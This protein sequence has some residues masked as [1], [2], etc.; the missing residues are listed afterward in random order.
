M[1]SWV[2]PLT[3]CQL[4]PPEGRI[5]FLA[6]SAGQSWSCSGR[7]CIHFLGFRAY[8]RNLEHIISTRILDSRVKD[9]AQNTSSDL[10]QRHMGQCGVLRDPLRYFSGDAN[11]LR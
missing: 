1:T 3:L 5:P 4:L 2:E 8:R 11:D 10:V 7:I 9:M 6:L